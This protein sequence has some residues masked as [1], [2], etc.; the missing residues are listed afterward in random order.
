MFIEKLVLKNF[1]SF[2]DNEIQFD[3]GFNALV[4]P[5]GSGKSNLTDSVV[6]AFG[7]NSLKSMRVKRTNDLIFG[8][9]SAAEVTVLLSNGEE[10]HEVKRMVR[11]SGE[12]KYLLN[13]KRVKKYVLE[14][15]LAKNRLFT[16]NVIKQGQVQHIV[17]VSSKDRR[18]MIDSVANISEYEAKKKEALSELQEV[19]DRLKSA[20]VILSEKQGYVE[21]LENEKRDAEKYL[22]LK[23]ELDVAKASLLFIDIKANGQEFEGIVGA[24][25]ESNAKLAELDAAIG[26]FSSQVS[27]L[28]TERQKI[29]DEILKRS[30]GK[31]LVMQQ[32]I[33]ELL[34]SIERSKAIIGEKKGFVSLERAKFSSLELEKVKASDEV[35]GYNEQLKDASQ[36]LSQV[37]K[38]LKKHE[39]ELNALLK[40]SDAF[41]AD[42][43]SAREFLE[44]SNE[45]TLKLR[46]RLSQVQAD[47]GKFVEV[48]KL[49]EAELQRLK[50]GTALENFAKNKEELQAKLKQAARNAD[51][52][53][54]ELNEFYGKE[55][56]LNTELGDIEEALL[57]T[58]T[59]LAELNSRLKTLRESDQS[60][61]VAYSKSLDVKG[62]YGT[63]EELCTYKDEYAL[64][65]QA[66]LGQRANYLVVDSA[67]TAARVIEALKKSRAGRAA[68]IPLDKIREVAISSTDEKLSKSKNCL[69]LLLDFIEYEKS[70]EKAFRYVFGSTLLFPALK[71]GED[72]VG[73]ARFATLDGQLA[74]ASG[75]ML[76]GSAVKRATTARD[77]KVLDDLREKEKVLQKSKEEV[78]S[79]LYAVRDQ[80]TIKRKERAKT[81]LELKAVEIELASLKAR[82]EVLMQKKSDLGAAVKQLEREVVDAEK[83]IERADEER[84][85]IIRGLSDLNVRALEAKQR[86]DVE[87]D[88]NF[89]FTIR[90]RE[91]KISDLKIRVSEVTGGI[92]SLKSQKNV[93]EKQLAMIQKQIDAISSELTE[94]SAAVAQHED[95]MKKET[96]SLK[97]KQASQKKLSSALKELYDKR[98]E[99]ENELQRIGTE[100]GRLE[101]DKE[102]I[103]RD[104]NTRNVRKAVVETNLQNLKA[105]YAPFEAF[106]IPQKET[107]TEE[108]KPAL[109]AKTHELQADI[110]SI[111]NV[112]LK[113]LELFEVKAKELE[114]QRGRV[115]Q[116]KT[117]KDSV[118]KLIDEIEGKKIITF[119]AAFNVIN[120]NFKSLF[121][122]VFRG[123]GEL[124]LENQ[125]NPFLGGLTI[126]VQ[127]DN[128]EVKYLELMSGGEKSLVAL[129]F[130]F[131]I[132]SYNPSSV[133]ILDEADAALDQE[134]SRKLSQLLKQLSRESQFLV[135]SHNQTVF[136]EADSLAGI[137]MGEAGSVL[138]EVKLQEQEAVV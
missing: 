4:G 75:V 110:E 16:H 117:E 58:R 79:A 42:F 115:D 64:A 65:V 32:E 12:T 70:F 95:K 130:L 18:Q 6:F 3:K 5:N 40:E 102:K 99:I 36:E 19:D 85:G 103:E 20:S 37:E 76:G 127:F 80:V 10:R 67:K 27:A 15:F 87:K 29:H 73:K 35:K 82:E 136:K 41:T 74:E 8:N 38:E 101:F 90:E 122:H 84:A 50:G 77:L 126:K 34:G 49:K 56:R 105:E 89:G 125:E 71:D 39:A 106:E 14:E 22:E 62:V 128:K 47:A 133:Y 33:D 24:M 57:S 123:N 120:N 135:V 109:L 53:E 104:F 118:L 72:L 92:E 98:E 83:E 113:A 134:N 121:K 137:A 100:K 1:K 132:Q 61:A 25:A 66:A 43:H 23:K 91:K 9:S 69:G 138:V 26:N 13:G 86:I 107:L 68:F 129:M 55:K 21:E 59:K 30:Q 54:K 7:E 46:E 97:E 131:A 96:V 114:E 45:E 11:K 112:N 51:V 94:A 119:M 93:Y 52:V 108:S 63:V 31:Q 78:V 44:K 124:F 28:N 88:K 2:R 111:G 17:E 60:R 81:E 48:K 116:L